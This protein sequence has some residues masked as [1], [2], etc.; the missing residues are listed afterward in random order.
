MHAVTAPKCAATRESSRHVTSC[1]ASATDAL[2]SSLGCS[3]ECA[4]ATV[5][6]AQ[7]CGGFI[8]R[9][10]GGG[11]GSDAAHHTSEACEAAVA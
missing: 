4:A 6:P 9:A 1:A 7:P 10:E 3:D 8:L 11:D 5:S 2:V